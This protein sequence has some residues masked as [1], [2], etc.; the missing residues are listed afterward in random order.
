MQ[1]IVF[2][3]ETTGLRPGSICQLAYIVAEIPKEG[4]GGGVGG[5]AGGSGSAGG[6]GGSGDSAGSGGSGEGV[7][8]A[9]N[10]YFTVGYVPKS[11]SDIHGLTADKLRELSGGKS[12]KD[13]VNEI[14]ADFAACDLWIA[15]N[16]DF[17]RSFLL[18][19]FLR[20]GRPPRE[21]RNYCTM[22][23][24]APEC[25]LPPTRGGSS[26]KY[27]TLKEAVEHLGIKDEDIRALCADAFRA[28]ISE[29]FHDARYDVA[30]TY[31]C[32]RAAVALGIAP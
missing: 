26:Y 32:F 2:D 14:K 7:V 9:K 10:M 18:M 25:K 22:K 28:D 31:L 15:H 20:V 23:E 1:V 13:R 24:L 17:D 5:G 21:A 19:E 12:F 30:A 8:E 6:A 4:G 16:I 27:P 3:T 29:R 11:A